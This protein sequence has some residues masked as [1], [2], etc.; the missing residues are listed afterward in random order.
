HLY[1]RTYER[2]V[3]NETLSC[4]TG[5]TAAALAAA[6]VGLSTSK[7]NCVVKTLGGDLNVKFDKVLEHTYY[8]IWLEGP[9]Q[10]VFKGSIDIE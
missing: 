1:V 9:A 6:S 2:G 7:N 8:N 3:E 5:V 10:L 4:G